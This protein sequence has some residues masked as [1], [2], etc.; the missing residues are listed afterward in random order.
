MNNRIMKIRMGIS[1]IIAKAAVI[2]VVGMFLGMSPITPASAQEV[3]RISKERVKEMMDDPGVVIIDVR[4][5]GQWKD[6][7][8]KIKG[9]DRQDPLD[10][11]ASGY[12][13][14]Q[15]MVLYCA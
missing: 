6:A 14:D 1:G 3:P 5:R 8:S 2:A 9:A 12:P 4:T 10:F 15:T 7:E 13:K 11:A